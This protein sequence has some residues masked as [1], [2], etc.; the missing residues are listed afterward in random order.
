MGLSFRYFP[1]PPRHGIPM[2][3]LKS[4]ASF[5]WR[6]LCL[7]IDTE[8]GEPVPFAQLGRAKG[9]LAPQR[10][11]IIRAIDALPSGI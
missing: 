7:L 10:D 6:Q 2:Q 8:H 5:Q 3:T 11:E 1:G 9:T 4:A